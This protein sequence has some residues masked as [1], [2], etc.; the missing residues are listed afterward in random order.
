ML[1]YLGPPD[2]I[3]PFLLWTLKFFF[4]PLGWICPLHECSSHPTVSYDKWVPQNEL[5]SRRSSNLYSI[6]RHL[7]SRPNVFSRRSCQRLFSL[8]PDSLYLAQIL[9]T[10]FSILDVSIHCHLCLTRYSFS[11]ESSEA[12]EGEVPCPRTHH[13]KDVPKLRGEKHDISLK[14]LHQ[15]GLETTRQAATSLTL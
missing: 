15:T 9:C 14:I 11:P 13:R 12:F 2:V 6:F 5:Q 3:L 1:N 4:L 8:S 7:P 10:L